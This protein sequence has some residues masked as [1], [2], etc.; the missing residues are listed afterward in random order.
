MAEPW[1]NPESYPTMTQPT[2]EEEFQQ[3]EINILQEDLNVSEDSS[4]HV[5]H[6]QTTNLLSSSPIQMTPPCIAIVHP[7]EHLLHSDKSKS[8]TKQSSQL[9]REKKKTSLSHGLSSQTDQD[10]KPKDSRLQKVKNI[11]RLVSQ[12]IL[13]SNPQLQKSK[14]KNTILGSLEGRTKEATLKKKRVAVNKST[15]T[16]NHPLIENIKEEHSYAELPTKEEEKYFEVVFQN[17]NPSHLNEAVERMMML[18][19]NSLRLGDRLNMIG[20]LYRQA[21]QTVLDDSFSKLL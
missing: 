5:I 4:P 11:K 20:E 13:S 9:T 17:E 12:S 6:L 14:K 19:K 15:S 2:M 1:M 16:V 7:N 3:Q 21:C 18:A 8:N 10:A